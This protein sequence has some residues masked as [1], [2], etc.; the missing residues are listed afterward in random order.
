MVV[1]AVDD[2]LARSGLEGAAILVAVSGGVDSVVLLEALADL[3]PRRR[4]ALSVG[5]VHHGLR[6]AEADADAAAVERAAARLGLPFASRRIDPRARRGS[7]P[8][9]SRPT[10]QEAARSLRYDALREMAGA[11]G[12]GHVATAHTLDDQAETVLMRV[13]RGVGPDGLGGIPEQSPDGV[14][15]RPLLGVARCEVEAF[16]VDRGLAWREDASNACDRYTRNRL[17]HHWLPELA[18]AFNPQLLR[19]L[20][21][22]AETQRRDAEWIERVVDEAAAELVVSERDDDALLRLRSEGWDALPEALARRVVRRLL[23]GVGA[24]RDLTHAH[25][26][27][28]LAFLRSERCAGRRRMLELP[29]GLRLEERRE[30]CVVRRIRP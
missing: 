1:E 23:V 30:V 13:L 22:L 10:L 18:R 29:G 24:G 21:R 9:R 4:L 11:A 7:G 14:L 25:V 20:G 8:S 12:A 2:A 28:V 3:A 6:G 15:V 27:R 19:A 16:A 26:L 17:R 5:H